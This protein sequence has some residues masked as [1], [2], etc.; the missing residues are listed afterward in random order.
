M[1]QGPFHYEQRR[2]ENDLVALEIFDPS[3]HAAQFVEAIPHI[4]TYLILPVMKSEADFMN[5]L[6]NKYIQPMPDTCLYAIINK[7]A[8]QPETQKY[9]GVIS[10]NATNPTN[11]VTEIGVM[12]FPAS[13]RTHVATNAIGLLLQY[14]LDPPS[15][16]GLGLRRVEWKCHAGN[17]ASR[18]IALRMGFELEG[19]AR[20]DRVFPG[21][22]VV[23]PV[24][25]LEK[26]NGTTGEVPGRHTAIYS[27]VWDE[28]DEKRPQVVAQM[29][30]FRR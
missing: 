11:A 19:I 3:V 29:E 21:G 25:A 14:T 12:I 26:R 7:S 5:E 18:K 23:L 8:T 4:S 6:Y 15:A 13:Q 1:A 20:W 10:L 17:E 22:A 2:L 9:A 30:R 27:I 28:W 24:D 16:G